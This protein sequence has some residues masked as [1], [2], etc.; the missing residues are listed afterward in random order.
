MQRALVAKE[1]LA[2]L[3]EMAAIVAHEVRNP[4]TI[5]A[6]ASTVLRKAPDADANLLSIIEEEA[7]RFLVYAVVVIGIIVVL[8]LLARALL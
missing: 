5:I 4:V 7:F 6:N 1:R 3:G 8:V 2:A